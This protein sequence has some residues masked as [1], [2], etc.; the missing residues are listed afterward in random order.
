MISTGNKLLSS[1]ESHAGDSVSSTSADEKPFSD[2]IRR[3]AAFEALMP[4]DSQT[5][6]LRAAKSTTRAKNGYSRS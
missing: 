2:S 3:L 6:L 4:I 5:I 1:G